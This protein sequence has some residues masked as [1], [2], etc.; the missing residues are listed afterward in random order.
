MNKKD[1]R[2]SKW[3]GS[4]DIPVRIEEKNYSVLC[5]IYSY[6]SGE[7]KEF[8]SYVKQK[9]SFELIGKM[10]DIEHAKFACNL[11]LKNMGYDISLMDF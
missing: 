7:K 10:T 1:K 5:K 6:V 9:D 2:G 8:A 3:V 4:K 11:A